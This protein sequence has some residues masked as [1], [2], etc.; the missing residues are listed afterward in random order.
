MSVIEID[1]N[2]MMTIPV[3][4]GI[5]NTQALVISAGSF[6]V[7]IPLPKEMEKGAEGWLATA[8]SRKELKVEAEKLAQEDAV[9]RA[10]RR[11]QL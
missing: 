6:F 3:Q 7:T 2:G 10:K 9:N 11:R 1:E 4:L 5:R 8:K